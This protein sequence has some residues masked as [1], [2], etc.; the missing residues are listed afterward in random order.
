MRIEELKL[1]LVEKIMNI[2]NISILERLGKL[3][4]ISN[5]DEDLTKDQIQMLEMAQSDIEDGNYQEDDS[6]SANL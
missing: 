5:K 2:E 6:L 3:F 4:N 1:G